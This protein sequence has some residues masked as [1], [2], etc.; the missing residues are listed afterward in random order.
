MLLLTFLGC[1]ELHTML[2]FGCI[3]SFKC[4]AGQNACSFWL[5]VGCLWSSSTLLANY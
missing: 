1:S 2:I 4:L 5:C 3:R